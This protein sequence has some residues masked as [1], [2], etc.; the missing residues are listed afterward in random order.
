MK[1]LK[2]L[3]ACGGT[4]GHIFPAFSVAEEIQ[5]R[6]PDAKIVY[7]CGHKDIENAIF[8]IVK[9][10]KV[11]SIQSAPFRGKSSLVNPLF[12]IKLFLGLFQA[13]LLILRERPSV[14]VGFG[15]HYSFPAVIVARWT[16]V[17]A[18]F[19][20]QNLVPG[21]ANKFLARYVDG[22]ALSF[23]ETAPKLPGAR[24]VRVTGNPIRAAI[25]RDCRKEALEYFGFSEKRIT[26]LVLGGSQGAES[27][28]TLFL[29]CL[30]FLP[31][32]HKAR[33]QVLHLCGKMNP[34]VSEAIFAREGVPAKV[35]SFFDRMDLAYGAADL[36]V[37]RAGA[38]FLAEIEAKEIPGILIPYPFAG[39]HQLLNARAFSR[40]RRAIVTEQAVTTP[41]KL[42]EYVSQFMSEIEVKRSSAN[43]ARPV[44]T[45]AREK[46]ADY[47]EEFISRS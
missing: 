26:A 18:L 29:G 35:Y 13:F 36:A 9:D 4:G 39:G 40:H 6:Y 23:E 17:P 20:E 30:P 33:L 3:L 37:G 8:K 10:R 2:V 34:A 16:G 42:A 27:I 19:H 41:E 45:S 14:V 21:T 47:I 31:A 1:P 22:A 5:K 7:V 25:E 32:E 12:L 28:N 46:L 38:T 15:G 43:G 44:K 24:N 11:Y